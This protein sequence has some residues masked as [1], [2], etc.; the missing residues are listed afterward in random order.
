M[1]LSQ[2]RVCFVSL[3]LI[4]LSGC[5]LVGSKQQKADLQVDSKVFLDKELWYRPVKFDAGVFGFPKKDQEETVGKKSSTGIDYRI[6][7]T[8]VSSKEESK[9]ISS[10]KVALDTLKARTYYVKNAESQY[11]EYKYVHPSPLMKWDTSFHG[12]AY[13]GP[14]AH[15]KALP[16][17][18]CD[19]LKLSHIS[20]EFDRLLRIKL[21]PI[22]KINTIQL[23]AT[24]KGV[25]VTITYQKLT[26]DIEQVEF[27]QNL[28]FKFPEG[29]AVTS[30]TAEN[31]TIDEISE[32]VTTTVDKA[33]RLY[34]GSSIDH[35]D[36][37]L[38]TGWLVVKDVKFQGLPKEH[39]ENVNK[40]LIGNEE[41]G[42]RW[43]YKI[44]KLNNTYMKISVVAS[45]SSLS[46]ESKI[47]NLSHGCTFNS[48]KFNYEIA[49]SN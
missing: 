36:D 9:S 34:G 39:H 19:D 37:G 45:N 20:F 28:T 40:M 41:D 15:L 12:F 21:I 26:D 23:Q 4:V 38:P 7:Y 31:S 8:F 6:V 10:H 22:S 1:V 43:L 17:K 25:P 35:T 48:P 2:F 16:N 13:V 33:K 30:L 5:E 42:I 24:S 29:D 44:K 18:S 3:G 47:K 27:T 14:A 11:C 32:F 49:S 46:D